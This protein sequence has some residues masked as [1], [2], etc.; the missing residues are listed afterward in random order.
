MREVN[1]I[2]PLFV[3]MGYMLVFPFS[4]FGESIQPYNIFDKAFFK[5]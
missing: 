4:F 2:H 3:L 1:S 5:I